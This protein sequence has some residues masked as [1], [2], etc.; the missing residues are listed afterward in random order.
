M[1]F[2][3]D[4]DDL[5]LVKAVSD[6]S[7]VALVEGKR[8]DETSFEVVFVR[9]GSPQSIPSDA[10]LTFGAKM[11]GRYDAEPVILFDD[12]EKNT[13]GTATASVT[14]GKVTS[15]SVVNGGSYY[16][17]EPAISIFGAGTGASAIAQIVDGV[18]DSII[19]TNE[20]TG[21]T[22]AP[23]I[24]I[25]AP[26]PRYVGS[27]NLN[28]EA[29]NDLF[30][31]D[32]DDE[33]D[34]AFVDL[35]AEFTWGETG[36]PSSTNTF[37]LRIHNDVLRG[38]EGTPL[39]LPT[40]DEWLEA[41]RPA[42][43]ILSEPPANAGMIVTGT[44]TDGTDPVTFPVLPYMD[45]YNGKGEYYADGGDYNINWQG[46]QFPEGWALYKSLYGVISVWTSTA[47]VAT[48]DL[49]P[50]GAWNADTNPDAWKTVSPATGTPVVAA[51]GTDGA[52]GQ[53]AIVDEEDVYVCTRTPAKWVQIS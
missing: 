8:G 46:S 28:T 29:L 34:P 47:D 17:T 40:P 44:L 27:P 51:V 30:Q 16:Q 15:I 33:N 22:S 39:P 19:V 53:L 48:P 12:F 3:I 6:K 9:N 5:K 10:V 35:M 42:P 7:P 38:D 31:I 23:T 45:T 4:L 49:V 26:D 52:V 14:D 21:Y 18:V 24:I 25:D 50:S 32:G 11:A 37:S 20:G 2:V 1:L 36:S 41:R 43:L 13:R